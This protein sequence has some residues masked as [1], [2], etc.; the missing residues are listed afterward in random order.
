[1]DNEKI[2]DEI[3]KWCDPYSLL[4]IAGKKLYVLSC[5]FKARVLADVA[6]LKKGEEGFVEAVKVTPDIKMVY[7]VRGQAYMFWLFQILLQ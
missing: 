4:V 7:I 6:G 1:M 2:L 3:R 5:P